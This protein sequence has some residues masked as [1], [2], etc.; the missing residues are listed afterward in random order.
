MQTPALTQVPTYVTTVRYLPEKALVTQNNRKICIGPKRT[1]FVR[2]LT[3]RSLPWL[4]TSSPQ[5][6]SDSFVTSN[7][8]LSCS[9]GLSS[10]EG[11][12]G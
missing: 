3:P 11:V 9:A 5:S 4:S 7:L 6:S 10:I 2:F 1:T 12:L 8:D